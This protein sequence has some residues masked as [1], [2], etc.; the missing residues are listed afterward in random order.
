MHR[1]DWVHAGPTASRS[2]TW[3]P[4]WTRH[5]W[6]LG[7][8]RERP[9][10]PGTPS[11]PPNPLRSRPTRSEASGPGSIPSGTRFPSSLLPRLKAPRSH[12]LGG[13]GW[14]RNVR[15]WL[16]QIT[17]IAQPSETVIG[18]SGRITD[19]RLERKKKILKDSYRT[20][21]S[22]FITLLT[23]SIRTAKQ[24]QLMGGASR[25]GAS[26]LVVAS[27]STRPLPLFYWWR[28]IGPLVHLV[29]H[30]STCM[31]AAYLVKIK[32][33]RTDWPKLLSVL[34]RGNVLVFSLDSGRAG[35]RR[36]PA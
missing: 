18:M 27:K 2:L 12:S 25:R 9:L 29:A 4:G 21:D 13:G 15:A 28:R 24:K 35:E 1:G 19:Q 36:L 31:R 30:T 32:W 26:R 7:T 8:R 16:F 6:S 3:C 14:E 34:S 20:L 11:G 33:G 10:R 17:R 23:F 5:K 22:V